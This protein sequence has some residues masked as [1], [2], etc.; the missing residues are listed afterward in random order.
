MNLCTKNFKYLKSDYA[1]FLLILPSTLITEITQ[2]NYVRNGNISRASP[3]TA[4]KFCKN[5]NYY[6]L[7]I[8]AFQD[9]I[10]S[11]ILFCFFPIKKKN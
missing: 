3:T 9:S 5:V 1:F 6:V 10:C 2:N 11:L 7:K 4:K 8:N